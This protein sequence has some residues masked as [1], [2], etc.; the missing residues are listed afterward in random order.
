[1]EK[2][3]T[4]EVEDKLRT[5]LKESGLMDYKSGTNHLDYEWMLERLFEKLKSFRPVDSHQDAT[6][7]EPPAMET[8]PISVHST[9]PGKCSWG[10]ILCSINRISFQ[11]KDALEKR[12]GYAEESLPVAETV[13]RP[14][15]APQ[16]LRFGAAKSALGR[17]TRN[18]S[19][20]ATSSSHQ[21]IPER[22][23]R[24]LPKLFRRFPLTSRPQ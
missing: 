21:P 13:R 3:L 1:M 20:G 15:I 7:S 14:G 19:S 2:V 18:N 4:P 11:R 16:W 23:Q 12:Q 5:G 10:P 22:Q 17:T 24:I 8:P 6:V 9:E